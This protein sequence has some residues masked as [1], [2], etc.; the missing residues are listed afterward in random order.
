MRLCAL[1]Y[2]GFDTNLGKIS[3]KS[4]LALFRTKVRIV[5]RKTHFAKWGQPI[6]LASQP[7]QRA[8]VRLGC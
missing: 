6:M 8:A 3:A 4:Q 7:D 5:E 1:C 2:V